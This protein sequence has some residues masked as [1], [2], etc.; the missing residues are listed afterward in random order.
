MSPERAFDQTAGLLSLVGGE[1]LFP[2]VELAVR[3]AVAAVAA[4]NTPSTK[5]GD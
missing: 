1:R 4:T 2:T 5:I 3:S